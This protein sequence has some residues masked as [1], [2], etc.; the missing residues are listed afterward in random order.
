[1]RA[2]KHAIL[3]LLSA[4]LCC[5]LSAD[6]AAQ[7]EQKHSIIEQRIEAIAAMLEEDS[8]LDFTTL[9]DDLADFYENPLNINT[10]TVEELQLLYMFT[11]L[12][13]QSLM[14]HRSRFGPLGSIYELQAVNNFDLQ[15]IR[16]AAPFITALPPVGLGKVGLKDLLATGK[17]DLFLRYRRVIEPQAGYQPT[18]DDGVIEPPAFR[19]SPDYGYLR[20]RCQFGRSLTVGITAEKDAGE[21]IDRGPD[22]FSGHV[23][24]RGK[25]GLRALVVGDY[26]A[27]FGQGLTYWSGLGFGKSPYVI[28]LKKNPL[29]LRP[30]TSVDENRFLRGAAAILGKDHLELTVFG[31]SKKI[32]GNLAVPEDTTLT[33]D[34]FT[35]TSFQSSGLH[36]T[37]SEWAD[38][39]VINENTAGANLRYSKRSL[40]VGVTGV[41]TAFDRSFTPGGRRYQAFDFSGNENLNIGADYQCV[42]RNANFFGEI[43]RS[44]NGA[45]AVLNGVV[46]SLHPRLS[47]AVLYR[48]FPA[49]Y[50]ALQVNVFAENNDRARNERGLYLAAETKL[51]SAWTLSL[52]AD[53][54]LFP[55]LTFN[56]DAPSRFTDYFMQLNCRPDKKHEFYL[57]YRWRS[58][59]ANV[60]TGE[61][62][63][64]PIPY[65]RHNVRFH[66]AYTAHPNI[67]LKSRFEWNMRKPENGRA[68]NGYLLYQDV[69]WKKL[70]SRLSFQAR[71]ALFNTPSWD[72]AIYAYE[73]D[74][75]YAYSIPAYSG[76]GSRIY[77]M[78]KWAATRGIDVWLRYGQ[79][80]YDDRSV[81]SSGNM[82]INANHKQEIH[83]QVRWQF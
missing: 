27:Q 18:E 82:Q 28:N 22:F 58:N 24:F 4:S 79:W 14:R 3:R 25:R 54:V 21:R 6:I 46:A 29:Q 8:E 52:Y 72:V 70:G 30:Y 51:A 81:I 35:I 42:I 17:N 33:D 20:Y 65:F 23:M 7:E 15:T 26:N 5:L 39:K 62:I 41:Y 60:N 47:L 64:Y 40:S 71:Y 12:Q 80:L 36:R 45:V 10:A 1:M 48:N 50:Q 77:A 59:E 19:G 34:E 16:M 57:R 69:I 53:Q 55:W 37:E 73:T 66:A 9:F 61:P 56:A 74:V 76:K 11:D 38:R 67:Q 83:V 68:T 2:V 78:A 32:D 43:S 75:L 63:D 13:I 31:S 44:R 49:D